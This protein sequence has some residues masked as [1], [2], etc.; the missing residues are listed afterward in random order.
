MPY[1]SSSAQPQPD[2]SSSS[3]NNTKS[4]R[5][6][7]TERL[8]ISTDT[9]DSQRD[10]AHLPTASAILREGRRERAEFF[11]ELV[12]L[13]F[14]DFAVKAY[15]HH[16]E[17]TRENAGRW[18]GKLFWFV[19][20]M[21]GHADMEKHLPNARAALKVIESLVKG[22]T[23]AAKAKQQTP[24][25]GFTGEA[26]RDWFGVA[27][28]DAHA[29]FTEVWTKSRFRPGHG[30]L[31]QAADMARRERLTMRDEVLNNPNRPPEDKRS[32]RNYSFF[33]S[34]AGHLQVIVGLDNIKLPCEAVSELLGISKDTVSRYRRWGM[35]DG[36]LELVKE[37]KF[38]GAKANNIATEFRF[39]VSNFKL[40]REL[41][42][43][44]DDEVF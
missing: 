19:W 38:R 25:F 39:D 29:E 8:R 24:P 33:L 6:Q 17:M 21:R 7:D 18:Q 15:Q 32:E 44:R 35:E 31:E 43:E 22:W 13:P 37:H 1:I 40:L 20:L 27:T 30:P 2:S 4:H 26:W 10:P 28:E 14:Y 41:A 34:V 12:E 42:V 23:K 5:T 36:Y 11:A 9:Q 3:S 16:W